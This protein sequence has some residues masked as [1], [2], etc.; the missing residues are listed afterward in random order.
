MTARVYF[1]LLTITSAP[2]SMMKGEK[3]KPSL[4]TVSIRYLLCLLCLQENHK[5]QSS[6]AGPLAP[7]SGR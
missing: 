6:P 5:V 2:Y 7:E 3:N 1:I 4:I